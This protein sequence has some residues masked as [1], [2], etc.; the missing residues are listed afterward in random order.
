GG[1]AY[2]PVEGEATLQIAASFTSNADDLAPFA[3]WGQPV[4]AQRDWSS[5]YFR[6]LEAG[7][8][9]GERLAASGP[10]DAPAAEA[11]LRTPTLVDCV[12]SM[13]AAIFEPTTRRLF[14]AMGEEPATKKRHTTNSK[15]TA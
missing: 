5:Q 9:L 4:R 14:A 15:T 8:L 11:I 13:N 6:S 1:A 10:L 2:G 3:F 7:A 12:D